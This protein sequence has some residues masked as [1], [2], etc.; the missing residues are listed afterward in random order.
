MDP[1]FPP[2]SRVAQHIGSQLMLMGIAVMLAGWSD[3]SQAAR[4]A[5]AICA[6][7]TG[8]G[9]Y[10][11]LLVFLTGSWLGKCHD[12]ALTTPHSDAS[13][14]PFLTDA[15]EVTE[16]STYRHPTAVVFS[17]VSTFVDRHCSGKFRTM[18]AVST[19]VIPT[20]MYLTHTWHELTLAL[21]YVITCAVHNTEV[22]LRLGS[23]GA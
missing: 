20:H 15:I 17:L 10:S 13:F 18:A 8:Y 9:V 23:V 22:K 11:V 12:W 4:Y 7:P 5:Q 2:Q 14:S 19:S 1:Q 6:L 21:S 16:G 3:I